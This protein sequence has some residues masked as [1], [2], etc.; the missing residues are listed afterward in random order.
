M[1]ALNIPEGFE[2]IATARFVSDGTVADLLM[3]NGRI[4]RAKWIALGRCTAW[5][6]MVGPRKQPIG[7]YDPV[8][9]RLVQ[10]VIAFSRAA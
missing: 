6:P 2:D 10:N 5:W 8:A 1:S 3:P 7:L 9:W 4:Y